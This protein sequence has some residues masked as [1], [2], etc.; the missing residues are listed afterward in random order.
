MAVDSGH[1]HGRA[2]E[3]KAHAG[4]IHTA[5]QEPGGLPVQQHT[6]LHDIV[7]AEV[8]AADKAEGVEVKEPAAHGHSLHLAAAASGADPHRAGAGPGVAV[9]ARL[10]FHVEGGVLQL[11]GHGLAEGH[12][13]FQGHPLSL[14]HKAGDLGKIALALPLPALRRLLAQEQIAHRVQTPDAEDT[15]QRQQ[16]RENEGPMLS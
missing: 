3:G 5:E 15:Q 10:L 1:H 6:V 2:V 4:Q 7:G 16:P 13:L 9:Q 8:V 14:G 12:H 11:L